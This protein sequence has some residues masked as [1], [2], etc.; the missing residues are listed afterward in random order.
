MEAVLDVTSGHCGIEETM[1]TDGFILS[2]EEVED[3]EGEDQ[4]LRR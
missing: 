1:D 3:D 4:G 2:F